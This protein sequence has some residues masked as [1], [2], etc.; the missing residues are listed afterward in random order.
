MW[1]KIETIYMNI[2]DNKKEKEITLLIKDKI[3]LKKELTQRTRLILP[4]F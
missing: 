3:N 1:T 4:I 2:F